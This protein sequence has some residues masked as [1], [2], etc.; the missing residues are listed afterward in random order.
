M[1]NFEKDLRKY[2]KE[3]L[4]ERIKNSNPQSA[5]IFSDE[6]TRRSND[7]WSQKLTYLTMLLFLLGMM[8][9]F[10]SFGSISKSPWIWLFL[11]IISSCFL[12]YAIRDIFKNRSKK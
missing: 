9:L 7:K 3:E 8:Q 4:Y 6:L 5:Y 2:T 1:S 12:F 10:V 11:I